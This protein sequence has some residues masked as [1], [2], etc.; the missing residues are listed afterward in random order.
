MVEYQEGQYDAQ[1]GPH[2]KSSKASRN[3]EM[4]S[5]LDQKGGFLPDLMNLNSSRNLS[6]KGGRNAR[7][8]QSLAL[9]SNT[10]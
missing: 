7:L 9:K 8:A 4:W 1:I 2:F 3:A 10:H 5:S 6:I